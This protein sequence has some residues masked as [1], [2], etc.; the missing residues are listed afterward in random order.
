MVA[1]IAYTGDP[2]TAG[3]MIALKY[4]AGKI[5]KLS[6]AETGGEKLAIRIGITL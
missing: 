5:A 6:A 1:G 4:S 3:G 2:T